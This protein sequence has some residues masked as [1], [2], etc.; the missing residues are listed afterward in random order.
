MM[1]NVQSAQKSNKVALVVE[2]GGMRGIFCA[3]VLDAFLQL[4]FD[5]FDIY[6]GVSSGSMN[7]LSYLSGQIRRNKAIYEHC[8]ASKEFINFKRFLKGGNLID[9]DWMMQSSDSI[10][11]L[12][13][14]SLAA[15]LSDT[16]KFYVV[17]SN[18]DKGC[19]QYI[20]PNTANLHT[21]V[22]ASS[23]IP[24]LYRF[25]IHLGKD[26]YLDG[27]LTDPIPVQKA[28][29]LGA[30]TIIVVRTR[31]SSYRKSKSIETNMMQYYYRSS[32]TIYQLI[33]KQPEIYNNSI[34]FIENPPNGVNIMQIAPEQPL[35]SGRTTREWH[36]LSHDYRTGYQLGIKAAETFQY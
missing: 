32:N 16:K 27:G 3:G 12:N 17:C 22:I 8:A 19:G 20:E 29:E 31:T 4:N 35:H 6:V 34:E 7:L 28:Y 24:V 9:L 18:I 2:G 5:P 15:K 14:E 36:R 30:K 23:A 1:N 21:V 10:C 11:P 13:K 25:P 33:N 26:Q